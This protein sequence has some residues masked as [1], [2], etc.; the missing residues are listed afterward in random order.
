MFHKL[1]SHIGLLSPPP[2][3]PNWGRRAHDIPQHT[4]PLISYYNL[5]LHLQG[6]ETK[7]STFPLLLSSNGKSQKY[8]LPS[9]T[10]NCSACSS[11]HNSFFIPEPE[12]LPQMLTIDLMH[13]LITLYFP[14]VT[15]SHPLPK[16]STGRPPWR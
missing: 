1:G 9:T 7:H 11:V 12:L 10:A 3:P 14:H 2:P 15:S 8:Y 16:P 5:H 4:N 13:F 6:L